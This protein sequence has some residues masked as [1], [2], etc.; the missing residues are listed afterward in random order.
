MR[1]LYQKIFGNVDTL[2][3]KCIEDPNIAST[4]IINLLKSDKP[5]MIAR[6]GST[7]LTCVANY[8]GVISPS[9]SWCKYVKGIDPPWWWN[10]KIIKQMNSTGGFFPTKIPE[11]SKFCRL[12][13]NDMKELD[14]LG[15]WTPVERYFENNISDIPK[16]NLALLDPYFSDIPWTIV[17]EGKRVLVIHPFSKSIVKQYEKRKLLFRGNVLPDFN[18]LTIKAVQTIGKDNLE[19]SSWFEALQY[20]KMEMDNIDY[21][22][23]LIGAGAYGFALAA[24]AKR[25]GK[26]AV[27]MG[28]SLQLLFGIRGRRWESLDYK[29]SYNER[30]FN[31]WSLMNEHWVRP[32]IEEKPEMAL[33]VE[34]GCYW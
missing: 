12:M 17:L 22:I 34:G 27:H 23:C 33:Q 24:H 7:E 13:L 11:I 21:D 6:F 8:L 19:Y 2:K 31:Y 29:F 5:V 16:I 14:L 18:L 15:S 26:K 9:N 28:G 25:Q 10:K 1:F 4:E 32:D 3:P 30:Q 20:M